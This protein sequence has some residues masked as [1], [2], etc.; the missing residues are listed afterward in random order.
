MSV[1]MDA[2]ASPLEDEDPSDESFMQ[3]IFELTTV[4]AAIMLRTSENATL[5]ETVGY[6]LL[7]T[8][9]FK[10]RKTEKGRGIKFDGLLETEEGKVVTFGLIIPCEEALFARRA[11]TDARTH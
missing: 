7:L 10:L 8:T 5:I 1:P 11:A 3:M 9:E 4:A 2:N 6:Q